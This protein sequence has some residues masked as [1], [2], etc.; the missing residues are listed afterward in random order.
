MFSKGFT[1]VELMMVLA[2]LAIIATV[3]VPGMDGFIKTNRL[4]GASD[5]LFADIQYARSE[6]IKRSRA[7]SVSASSDGAQ[8]WCYGI[9]QTPG[10]D[11]HITDTT[12]ANACVLEVAGEKILK[13]GTAQDSHSVSMTTPVGNQVTIAGFDPV[14]GIAT[15]SSTVTFNSANHQETQISVSPLGRVSAC[16]PVG[17]SSVA[18]Y[19][20]C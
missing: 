4:R 18:G 5:G 13:I 9:S 15:T 14:R 19:T 1:L 20:P 16:T 2:V 8:N 7:I 10:C 17:S 11:C 3:A 6:S 12:D